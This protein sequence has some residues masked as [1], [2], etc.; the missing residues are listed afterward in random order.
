M[1]KGV[2]IICQHFVPYT[3]SVGGV[4]RVAYLAK[5][6]VDRGVD[7]HVLTSNGVDYGYLG[8]DEHLSRV[9]VN[10][11][12]DPLKFLVQASLKKATANI[13]AAS[14][15]SFMSFLR[16]VK[17]LVY[18]LVIPDLGLLMVPRYYFAASRLITSNG[19]GTVIVSTPPHSMQIVGGLL[20]KR[21]GN[22]IKLVA[23]YRDSW[24]ASI[25]FSPDS[26]IGSYIS[27]WLERFCLRQADIVTFVSNPML[28]KLCALYPE[29]EIKAK[30]LLV[31]NGFAGSPS[32]YSG[33]ARCQPLRIGYFGMADDDLNGYRNVELLFKAIAAANSAGASLELVFYGSL[34]LSRLNVED[35]P[36]VQIHD[37][38]P[39]GKVVEKM[40]EMDYLLVLHTDPES[41]DEVVTGKFFDYIQARRPMLC[42]S[43]FNMEAARIINAEKIGVWADSS[44]LEHAVSA[45]LTLV[46]EEFPKL[47]DSLFVHSF[48]RQ[49]QYSR[50]IDELSVP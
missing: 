38:V 7:V 10:Y 6:L 35:Y 1:S 34:R 9:T 45:F 28:N 40:H 14:S 5:Q 46:D 32:E 18:K 41:S 15:F 30:G 11:L 21:F 20:K 22:R 3:P 4:A 12:N 47:Q 43:P 27:K 29:L 37:P 13:D 8:F 39:H 23:D 16:G 25:I 36:F 44:S 48:S 17:R 33:K 31:M 49:G 2:L 42:F 24:N 19:I 26:T 50:L